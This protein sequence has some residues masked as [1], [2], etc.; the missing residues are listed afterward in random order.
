M[1]SLSHPARMMPGEYFVKA[2]RALNSACKACSS[3]RQ[4]RAPEAVG[5]TCAPRSLSSD[6]DESPMNGPLFLHSGNS[7]SNR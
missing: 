1:L 3:G 7:C 6:H 2:E 4:A 5:L